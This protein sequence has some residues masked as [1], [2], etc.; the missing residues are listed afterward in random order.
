MWSVHYR[1]RKMQWKKTEIRKFY[2]YF[3]RNLSFIV[4]NKKLGAVMDSQKLWHGQAQT[5]WKLE[6]NRTPRLSKKIVMGFQLR[7]F[8][9]SKFSQNLVFFKLTVDRSLNWL[10]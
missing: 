4:L 5:F 8:E 6:Y 9:I 10:S 1:Q 3:L 2:F 7:T